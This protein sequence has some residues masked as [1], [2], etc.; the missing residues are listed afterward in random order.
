[1]ELEDVRAMAPDID[2]EDGAAGE[3]AAPA[4]THPQIT[5]AD[6]ERITREV[7]LRLRNM[8]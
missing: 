8:Q 4:Q 1:M 2:F 6:I 5:E 7:L 3:T